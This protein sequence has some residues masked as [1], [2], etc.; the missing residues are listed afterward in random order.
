MCKW[1][2]SLLSPKRAAVTNFDKAFDVIVSAEGGY[3]SDPLDKGN[4][5]SGV[6]GKGNLKGT[7]Y[8]ISAAA[9][10]TIDIQALTLEQAKGIYKRD[11]WDVL[12]L[13]DAEYPFALVSFDAAV[14]M[15]VNYAKGLILS[16]TQDANFVVNFQAERALRYAS[17]SI[18]PRYGKGWMR[19]LVRIAME[20]QK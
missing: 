15:G 16:V 9:Y 20:S 11:Y 12:Q 7:K 3:T 10:P 5:D 14:N 17:L 13:D 8:G 4:W 6:V 1:L 2:R 18:F 19:R